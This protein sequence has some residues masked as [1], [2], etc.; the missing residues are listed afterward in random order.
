MKIKKEIRIICEISKSVG[1]GHLIRSQRLHERLKKNN[2]SSR[3]YFNYDSQQIENL[4]L[5]EKKIFYLIIDY[6]NYQ[7]IHFRPNRKI[8]KS[9]IFENIQKKSF[10]NSVNIFPLD[11]QFKKYSGPS[12]FEYP[13]KLEKF[14]N[15]NFTYSKKS[16]NILIIQGGTD[17]NEN[18]NNLINL[19][20][21]FFFLSTNFKFNYNLVVKTNNKLKIKKN[22][23]NIKNVK[24]V[25]NVKFIEN[26]YKKI[27]LAISA[28]GNTAFELGFLGIPTIHVTSEEREKIRAKIFEKK[29]LAVFA[30][31]N[32]K[33]K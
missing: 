31:P 10:D 21:F 30:S 2:F 12:Y 22:F 8:I 32:N 27:D 24:I 20:F 19:F 6:K 16:L 28:C 3:I 26:I 9:I 15:R 7:R 1:H 4:I 33:K 11:I 29:G 18:L 23:F 13:K 14:E 25:G 5:R 17:A